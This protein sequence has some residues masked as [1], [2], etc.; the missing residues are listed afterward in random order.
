MMARRGVLGILAGGAAFVLGG[1]SILSSNYSYRYK[2][3]VEVD[4]PEGLKTGYAVHETLV[5]K[6]NVDLGDI[7]Q[8]QNSETRGEAVAV[9]LPGG[10]T[11]FVLM[12]NDVAVINALDPA[13][14]G[15]WLEKA[16]RVADGDIPDGPQALLFSAP[17]NYNKS[18]EFPLFV[19]FQDINN[20]K[21]VEL[22]RPDNLAARFG[23]GVK[24]KGVTVEVT[25]E[26]VTVG[27]KKRLG[28]LISVGNTNL[29]SHPG[30]VFLP[31]NPS[32]A[33]TLAHS[34][35]KRELSK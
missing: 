8:K 10:Q 7:S 34:D 22:V 14:T 20:P 12:P 24:L 28:W 27:I 1:C 21:T 33:E 30:A 18:G 23:G 16:L 19:R 31:E 6:S 5:S 29:H 25:D 2:M 3:T 9:D 11:L 32:L 35:F 15:G 17:K 13:G 4:T 26:D